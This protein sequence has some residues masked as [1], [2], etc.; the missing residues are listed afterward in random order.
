M[1]MIFVKYSDKEKKSNTIKN[2][3]KRFDIQLNVDNNFSYSI[4]VTD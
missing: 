2:I 3:K 1:F 4:F